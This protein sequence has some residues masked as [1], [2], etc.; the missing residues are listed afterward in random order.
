MKGQM[1]TWIRLYFITLIDNFSCYCWI[2]FTT[3]K[4]TKMIHDI[5]IQ[6]KADV[7][8][9]A[10]T[11][12]SYLQMD[13]GSKHKREMAKILKAGGTMHIPSSSHSHKSNGLAEC[14]N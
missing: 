13:C 8:N 7:E 12:V 1:H 9:K 10:N 3:H 4:D 2:Y 5:Y 11:S 6:W 14:Q